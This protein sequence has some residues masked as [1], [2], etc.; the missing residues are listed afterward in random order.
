MDGDDVTDGVVGISPDRG[1]TDRRT[2]RESQEEV[3]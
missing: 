1:V 3:A 2:T